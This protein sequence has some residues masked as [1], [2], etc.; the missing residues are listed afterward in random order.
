MN[1]DEG[2]SFKSHFKWIQFELMNRLMEK[3]KLNCTDRKTN[4]KTN[5]TL[6]QNSFFTSRREQSDLML[7][8]LQTKLPIIFENLKTIFPSQ[9][10]VNFSCPLCSVE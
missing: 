10:Q 7:S 4:T 5:D 1:R 6:K 9:T 8:K 2:V 3:K